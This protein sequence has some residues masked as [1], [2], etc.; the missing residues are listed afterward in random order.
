MQTEGQA[1]YVKAATNHII[2]LASHKSLSWHLE[3]KESFCKGHAIGSSVESSALPA[4]LGK[5]NLSFRQV[6]FVEHLFFQV[7]VLAVVLCS[8]TFICQPTLVQLL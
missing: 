1:S 8:P 7:S 3:D 6:A 5:T 2:F 4:S